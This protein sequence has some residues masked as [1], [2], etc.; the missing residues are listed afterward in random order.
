MPSHTQATSLLFG[1]RPVGFRTAMASSPSASA[2][3]KR[4]RLD[5]AI[6][7]RDAFCK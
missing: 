5:D 7:F 4:G 2:M 6:Q 1:A 3:G